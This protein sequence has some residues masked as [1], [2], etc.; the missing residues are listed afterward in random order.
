MSSDLNIPKGWSKASLG[1]IATE[2]SVR[3]ANPAESEYERFVGSNHIGR[4]ELKISDWGSTSEVTSAMKVF[5][6]GDYLLV[7]RS[8][9]ASDFRERAARADFEGVCSGDILTIREKEGV[10]APGF[11]SAV[12]NTPTIWSYVVAHATGSITRRIKWRQLQQYE[13]ALPPLEEQR[14]IAEVLQASENAIEATQNAVEASTLSLAATHKQIVESHHE[15]QKS[16]LRDLCRPDSPLCYGVIQPG[17]DVPDGIPLIRVCDIENESI[18]HG[19]L[20]R[21]AP[22]I[23]ASYERSRVEEGDLLV[24]IV[25]TIGRV[26]IAT[27]FEQGFNIARAIARIRIREECRPKFVAAVLMSQAYQRLLVGESFETARKTLNLSALGEIE[28]PVPNPEAQD[29]WI[30]AVNSIE[31]GRRQLEDRARQLRELKGS[32]L[33]E[34]GGGSA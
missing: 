11:L 24:S 32:L 34:L 10:I 4:F 25:G 26:F 17:N 31:R 29:H 14:R 6:P 12:L 33:N 19:A 9:Y 20:K 7:R 15:C 27:D 1:D 23:D 16:K 8:L 5:Q 3:V 30:E 18:D 28:V 13:F 2:Y 22:E 21:I